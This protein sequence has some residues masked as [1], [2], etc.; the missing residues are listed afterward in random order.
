MLPNG[1][2]LVVGGAAAII[3]TDRDAFPAVLAGFLKQPLHQD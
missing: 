1:K 3:L 2:V